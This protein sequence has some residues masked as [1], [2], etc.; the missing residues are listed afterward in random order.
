VKHGLTVVALA[1]CQ[2][3]SHPPTRPA[4]AAQ[5]YSLG[6]VVG[7]WRWMLRTDEDGTARVEDE[8]WRF[9]PDHAAPGRLAGRYVRSVEVRSSDRLPFHCNQRAWYRQRALFDVSVT[10]EGDGFHVEETGYITE[11]SP[12]DHGFRQTGDYHARLNGNRLQLVFTGGDQT[13]WQT[14]DASTALQDAPWPDHYDPTGPWRWDATAYD[15]SGDIR[16]EREWWEVTA[17]EDKTKLDLTYRRRVTITSADG[18]PIACA[19]APT[20]SFDDAYVL[21]GQREEEH[22]HLWERAV[23]PGDHPCLRATP[24]RNLDEAT[25]E[26][27]GDYLV[28]EWRG[29]R[30]Q[31]LYRPAASER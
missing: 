25:A 18:K 17:R 7:D 3:P 1:A 10:P 19:N 8:H 22:W 11:P 28:L 29:K 24:E 4:P 13:L 31:V 9:A 27:I 6:D 21:E 16:D 2:P 5:A 12:C 20:W 14:N 26:Q 30:R 23:A 15:P